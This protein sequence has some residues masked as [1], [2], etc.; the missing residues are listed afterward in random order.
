MSVA[1]NKA[2]ILAAVAAINLQG[3]TNEQHK[4]LER[5]V[6]EPEPDLAA[7][8]FLAPGHLNHFVES[9]YPGQASNP[10]MQIR[11][12]SMIRTAVPDR[13]FTIEEMIGEGDTVVVH[14]THR[15]THSGKVGEV[16]P[17]G[18]AVSWSGVSIVHF[19]DGKAV[20]TWHHGNLAEVLGQLGI[21][22]P[23]S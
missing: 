18:R 12:V 21:I 17:T 6:E 15:G 11:L 13:Q 1:E 5:L 20:E 10:N 2:V 16:E 4:D 7:C 19:A 14:G 3:E 9:I 8:R 23:A 22:S